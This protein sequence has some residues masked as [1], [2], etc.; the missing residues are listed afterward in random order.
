MWT[1][2]P[3]RLHVYDL[4]KYVQVAED[5]YNLVKSIFQTYDVDK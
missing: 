2:H 5:R 3:P 1:K 4:Q